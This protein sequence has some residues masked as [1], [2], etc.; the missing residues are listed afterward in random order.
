MIMKRAWILL[1]IMV[2]A[3]F[4]AWMPSEEFMVKGVVTDDSGNALPGVNVVLKGTTYG[5][6]TDNSGNYAVKVKDENS[7]L[8]FSFVGFVTR[9]VRVGSRKIIDIKLISDN[10]SLDE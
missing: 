10:K 4:S 6:V 7:I 2:S 3:T 5:D 9:E 8:V 1:I